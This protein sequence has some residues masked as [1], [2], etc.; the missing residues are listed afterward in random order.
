MAGVLSSQ[1]CPMV[2]RLA[3]YAVS[4]VRYVYSG[5]FNVPR[6]LEHWRSAGRRA[7]GRHAS[8]PP[9]TPPRAR[10]ARCPPRSR[11]Y[12]RRST[13]RDAATASGPRVN[14]ISCHRAV[15]TGDAP[16]DSASPSPTPRFAASTP[17]GGWRSNSALQ[18]TGLAAR[19]LDA[20]RRVVSSS[21]SRSTAAVPRPAAERAQR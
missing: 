15:R 9:C 3:R 10:A 12:T 17:G 16:D 18:L 2:L 4:A 11:G 7:P 13:R 6:E 5:A 8:A 1:L 14:C 19:G 20:P 21:R